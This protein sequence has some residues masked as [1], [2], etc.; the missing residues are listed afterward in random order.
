MRPADWLLAFG[1]T[2]APLFVTATAAGPLLHGAVCALLAV[3]GLLLQVC[4]N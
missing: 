4:A 1:A 3:A 2:A